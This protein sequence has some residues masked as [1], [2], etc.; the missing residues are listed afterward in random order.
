MIMKLDCVITSVNMNHK[1]SQFIP[2]FIKSWS[3][4]LPYIDIKIILINDFIP[5]EYIKYKDNIIL[6]KPIDNMHTAFI[7]QYIR[8]LYPAILNYKNGILISD[9]DMIPMNDFYYTENI[10]NIADNKFIV[11]RNV[12]PEECKQYPICYNIAINKVWSEIFNIKSIDDIIKSLKKA[13]SEINYNNIHGGSGWDKD[14]RDLYSLVLNY[15]NTVYLKDNDCGFKRLDKNNYYVDTNKVHDLIKKKKYSDYHDI[16]DYDLNVKIVDLIPKHNKDLIILVIASCDKQI[17]I[18]LIINHWIKYIKYSEYNYPN[19]KIFLLF[20][21]NT[22][23]SKFS[24]IRE[25]ILLLDTSE[26]LIPGVLNK[27]ILS[28]EKINNAFNYNY[29]LRTNLSSFFRLDLLLE[30]IKNINNIYG[31]VGEH[32]NIKFVSGAGILLTKQNV[33]YI[34]LNKNKIN[35][36]LPDDVALSSIFNIQYPDKKLRYDLI[37]NQTDINFN[38]INN[39]YH[40]RIKN[41]NRENDKIIFDKL[42]RFY[43]EKK[44]ISY[45]LYGSDKKYCIGMLENLKI[46]SVKLP[47]WETYIYYSDDVPNE[48]IEMYKQYNPVLINCGRTEYKWEG[49]FWRFKPFND[50]NIDIFLS[51]DADSRI[52]DREIKFINE[53]IESKYYFHIIRDHYGHGIEILGGT[54]GVKV[55]EFNKNYNIKNIN[56]YIL[57][58]R[59]L[60]HKNIQKQPDQHFLRDKIWTLIKND[61]YCHIALEQLRYC[62]TDIITSMVPHFIGM[63]VNIE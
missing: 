49:M 22:D 27:T 9:M 3:R 43:C 11:F 47:D 15:E 8:I 31:V 61:N 28:F 20:S 29:I 2:L 13:Y 21:K 16:S 23:V 46:N 52:T 41:D 42:F 51:R 24:D 32:D 10:K 38:E 57:E 44:V 4:L 18:D 1:Y 60:Y 45:S 50:N 25:N 5:D 48:Y 30:N 55:K 35:N 63:D 40:F 36:V 54:F 62:D 14:Q 56:E 26:D 17:Y 37:N 58:Y 12:L 53:F 6:F 19:I 34:L 7:A 33:D 39:Y 59:K